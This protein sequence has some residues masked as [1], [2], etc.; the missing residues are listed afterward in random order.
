MKIILKKICT[1]LF[2]LACASALAACASKE[3][4]STDT[5]GQQTNAV[6]GPSI[7]FSSSNNPYAVVVN[8]THKLPDN[9]ESR[10]N[11]IETRN[12]VED[13]MIEIEEKTYEAYLNLREDLLEN[14]GVQIELDSVYRSVAAQQELVDWFTQEYGE[15]Y[16]KTYAAV[17]GYSEHHTGLA[18]DIFVIDKDGQQIRE[19]DDMIADVDDFKI[20]HSKLAKYGF[21]LRYPEGKQDITGYAYEPWHFRYLDDPQVAKEITDKG[22]TLEEYLGIN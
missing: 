13:D 10:V 16:A 5:G 7:I 22:L 1:F 9:W 18:V 11:I 21:I 2:V 6:G 8:K 4:K 19:N 17:P 20:I 15:E 14:D 12:T 3:T